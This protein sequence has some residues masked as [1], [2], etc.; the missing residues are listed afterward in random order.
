MLLLLLLLLLLLV[1]LLLLL[2]LARRVSG[3]DLCKLSVANRPDVDAA[4]ASMQC[5]THK[6]TLR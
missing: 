5:V 3:L 2:L 4:L 6:I 1:L